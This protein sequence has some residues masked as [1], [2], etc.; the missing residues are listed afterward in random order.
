MKLDF[1]NGYRC[2]FWLTCVTRCQLQQC[3][4]QIDGSGDLGNML[5]RGEVQ[6]PLIRRAAIVSWIE[7]VVEPVTR[8]PRCQNICRAFPSGE[9]MP[10]GSASEISRL[11]DSLRCC[12]FQQSHFGHGW[13]EPR[14][15]LWKQHYAIYCIW[16]F[17]DRNIPELI[18]PNIKFT[19]HTPT[20]VNEGKYGRPQRLSKGKKRLIWILTGSRALNSFRTTNTKHPTWF[21][22]VTLMFHK[23]NCGS[24]SVWGVEV[25]FFFICRWPIVGE[26]E[27]PPL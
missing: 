4:K 27:R 24:Y 14:S 22:V 12:T 26:R 20:P 10:I 9:V 21:K 2:R 6:W 5:K 19:T 25:C 13:L 16:C 7:T 8:W 15:I 1:Y 18:W 17:I 11:Q 23:R 3:R